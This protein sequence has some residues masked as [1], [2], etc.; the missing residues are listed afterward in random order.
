MRGGLQSAIVGRQRP[1]AIKGRTQGLQ[2]V[3]VQARAWHSS[4]KAGTTREG[5]AF[6]RVARGAWGQ[7][8]ACDLILIDAL[9]ATV[10]QVRSGPVTYLHHVVQ[11]AHG[12]HAA[13][14]VVHVR[15]CLVD[16]LTGRPRETHETKTTCGACA[17]ARARARSHA[18]ACA[19]V[20]ASRW[21]PSSDWCQQFAQGPAA[22]ARGEEQERAGSSSRP[23]RDCE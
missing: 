9:C 1:C 18:R 7:V 15:V 10:G 6:S 22:G 12:L 4:Y 2:G 13:L 11:Q 5:V 14:A 21:L 3:L 8:R 19:R 16:H 20:A 23:G 17:R